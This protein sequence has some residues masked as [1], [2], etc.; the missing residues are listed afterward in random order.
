MLV[1]LQ[2]GEFVNPNY[3]EQFKHSYR[4]TDGLENVTILL[5]SGAEIKLTLSHA[6]VM[7]IK[8][9]IEEAISK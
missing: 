6:D 1:K 4:H 8:K 2:N 3:V 7:T 5:A 9:A